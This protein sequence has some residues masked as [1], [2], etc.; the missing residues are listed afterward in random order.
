MKD[1]LGDGLL[2]RGSALG[3]ERYRCADG[4]RCGINEGA[5]AHVQDAS[6]PV[7]A[8]SICRRRGNGDRNGAS[9]PDA[10]RPGRLPTGGRH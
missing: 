1:A 10:L 4:R 5:G 7:V 9:A 8:D 6:L 2:G 3:Y